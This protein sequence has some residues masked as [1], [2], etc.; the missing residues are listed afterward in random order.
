MYKLQVF[1]D[2]TQ[3]SL[4]LR[5]LCLL[6][7]QLGIFPWITNPRAAS[8]LPTYS[9]GNGT[10]LTITCLFHYSSAYRG[11]VPLLHHCG[12]HYE[13]ACLL[14]P[15]RPS[16]CN[17]SSR[18]FDKGFR[19]AGREWIHFAPKRCVGA[20]RTSSAALLALPYNMLLPPFLLVYLLFIIVYIPR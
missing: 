17:A 19:W 9:P 1:S 4:S 2:S 7:H 10:G 16:L 3:H 12:P 13:F 8:W 20:R 14:F 5:V 15:A 18:D 11:G 6:C